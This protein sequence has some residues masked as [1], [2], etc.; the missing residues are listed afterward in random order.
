MSVFA[1]RRRATRHFGEQW[2]PFAEVSLRS[3]SG[4]WHAFSVQVDTGA[5]ISVVPRSAGELLGIVPDKGEAVDLAGVG[6]PPQR[7]FVHRFAARIGDAPDFQMRIAV[8]DRED[9]P[10]LL[11]RL[12]ILD[13]FQIDLD[14]SL[15]ETRVSAPWLDADNRRIWRCCLKAEASVLRAW[16]DHPLPGRVDEAAKRFVNRADQLVAA[17]AGLLKLHRGSELPLIIRSLFELSVQFE[18]LMRDPEARAELYIDYEHVT[19]YRSE[20]AWL[21]FPGLVGG[22]LRASPLRAAEEKRNRA[23]YDRVSGR[24]AGRR[25]PT[26]ARNHWYPGSLRTL[27][28]EAGRTAEYDAVYGL[29]SAWAHGDPWTSGLR[30]TGYEGLWHVLAYWSR[31]LVQVADAKRMILSGEEYQ[32][33][34]ELARGMT[35][36][37]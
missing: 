6:A 21:K 9:A 14:V 25:D 22:R 16:A 20:Q 5:V 15:E 13:R 29:Y 35:E 27:A 33:L 7:Y 28:T 11:G 1:W 36:T 31:I 34:A 30:E 26:Q 2:V 24:Y 3:T 19:R 37:H 23:E 10:S 18:Y 12:D 4:R 8:A 32:V 17:G